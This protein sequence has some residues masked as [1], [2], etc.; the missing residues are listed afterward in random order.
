[1]IAIVAIRGTTETTMT[2]TE[3]IV[4]EVG[5]I[6]VEM[7]T[8]TVA[9]ATNVHVLQEG[10]REGIVTADPLDGI[11]TVGLA[12]LLLARSTTIREWKWTN[13][14]VRR[15]TKNVALVTSRP[16]GGG[17]M[18]LQRGVPLKPVERT[19]QLVARDRVIGLGQ[20]LLYNSKALR[21]DKSCWPSFTGLGIR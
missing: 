1:V 15:D 18:T 8:G 14:R 3:M 17:T 7:T 19:G 9:G 13:A 6:V 10:T 4:G 2:A 20:A 21:G 16:L 5:M 12:R 11:T